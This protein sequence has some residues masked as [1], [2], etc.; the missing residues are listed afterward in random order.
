LCRGVYMLASFDGFQN[1]LRKTIPVLFVGVVNFH[2]AFFFSYKYT[3]LSS[4]HF[5]GSFFLLVLELKN[6]F[7]ILSM[8]LITK[9][10]ETVNVRT[11]PCTEQ[12][13]NSAHAFI[14][15]TRARRERV[16]LIIY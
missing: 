2:F 7:V 12:S 6:L 13:V 1:D 5:R 8:L 16:R 11:Y 3:F 10:M 4:K 9:N 14:I 15:F